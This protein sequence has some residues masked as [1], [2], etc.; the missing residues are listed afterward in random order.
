MRGGDSPSYIR[1]ALLLY[2]VDDWA[3]PFRKLSSGI[4]YIGVKMISGKERS[5]P[6]GL[7]EEEQDQKSDF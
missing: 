3:A 6:D 4:I 5:L 1:I 2:V 7:P